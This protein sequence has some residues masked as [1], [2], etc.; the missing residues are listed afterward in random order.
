M[1]M[2]WVGRGFDRFMKGIPKLEMRYHS[3]LVNTR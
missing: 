1:I 2:D 3:Y